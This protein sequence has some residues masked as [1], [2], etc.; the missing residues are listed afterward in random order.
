MNEWM[1]FMIGSV[2]IIA[3]MIGTFIW[4]IELRLRYT[5][6]DR[7]RRH[8]T[9]NANILGTSGKD[10]DSPDLRYDLILGDFKRHPDI[11]GYIT[12]DEWANSDWSQGCQI[13][14]GFD[15]DR[16]WDKVKDMEEGERTYF[17]WRNDDDEEESE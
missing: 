16:E 5:Y 2:I 8:W 4:R 12:Y 17:M 11:P 9:T 1:L 3:L 14:E 10:F 6:D 15:M 7:M 13:G